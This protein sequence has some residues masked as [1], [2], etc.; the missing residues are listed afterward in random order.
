MHL[1]IFGFMEYILKGRELSITLP[2]GAS[3]RLLSLPL[4]SNADQSSYPVYRNGTP[5]DN[6]HGN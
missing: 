6:V 5:S 2:L 3:N 1:D 4:L